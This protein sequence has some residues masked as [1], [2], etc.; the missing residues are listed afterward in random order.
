MHNFR[1]KTS[2]HARRGAVAVLAAISLVIVVAF[3]AFSVDYGRIV[4]TES[5]LQNAAD[6]GALSAARAL[7]TDRDAA[8]AAAQEWAAKNFAAAE[9]VTLVADEDVELGLWD[10][11]TALFTAL[12]E[13]SEAIPT[14]VRVTCRRTVARGN[15]IQ[16]FFAPILGVQESNLT[17]SSVAIR[18]GSCGGIMAINRVYLREDSY[19]DSYNSSLADYYSGPVGSNGDVC[20]NGHIRLLHNAGINGDAHY[21]PEEDEVDMSGS[22]YVTGIMAALPDYIDFPPVVL[23]N[24]ASSN[25]NG[26]IPD[27]ENGETA[28][29]GGAFE[30]GVNGTDSLELPPG[31]YYFANGMNLFNN[32]IVNVTG[33]TYIYIGDDVSLQEGGIVNHT[34]IPMNLQ[35]YPLGD[36][37]FLSE[38]VD[39][40]AVIYTIT[41]AIEKK[42]GSAGFFGKMVGQKIKIEGTGGLHV[43]ES[44]G[45]GDLLSGAEQIGAKGVHLVY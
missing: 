17:V 5:E 31:T 3:L 25:D 4:V 41:S 6:A 13:N 26:Q 10:E 11:D 9:A 12:P 1:K 40:H 29:V 35:I 42:G 24:V 18:G 15:A 30:L 7:S 36:K 20:T 34:G 19:T 28:L 37:F 44:I 23:G 14:A 45:F 16:L 33:P 8:I 27:S 22:N 43:D 39:L 21:G 32:S 38:D 2:R